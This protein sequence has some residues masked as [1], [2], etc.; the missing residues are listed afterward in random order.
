[1][2]RPDWRPL[3]LEKPQPLLHVME[4]IAATSIAAHRLSG[5][6]AEGWSVKSRSSNRPMRICWGCSG[7]HSCPGPAP[8]AA[9]KVQWNWEY[10]GT[11]RSLQCPDQLSWCLPWSTQAAQDGPPL[12]RINL[13]RIGP[14][15]LTPKTS[16]RATLALLKH[17]LRRAQ[18]S[19][20]CWS[21]TSGISLGHGST[22]WILHSFGP[23]PTSASGLQ[24]SWLSMRLRSLLLSWLHLGHFTI[25]SAALELLSSTHQSQWHRCT[26]L[27]CCHEW[28]CLLAK[29]EL[30]CCFWDNNSFLHEKSG[31][32]NGGSSERCCLEPALAEALTN[33]VFSECFFLL[34]SLAEGLVLREALF[35]VEALKAKLG[36]FFALPFSCLTSSCSSAKASS[37]LMP[38]TFWASFL[39]KFVLMLPE[40]LSEVPLPGPLS[41][42]FLIHAVILSSL[43]SS[44]LGS[45]EGWS[46]RDKEF[47][48]S[49]SKSSATAY[50]ISGWSSSSVQPFSSSRWK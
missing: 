7:S 21:S 38:C 50:K 47:W 42:T 27:R 36:L 12:S 11:K 6:V 25:R 10:T 20:R 31:G 23:K 17:H 43:Q 49:S 24:L 18:P 32:G 15:Q 22:V 48:S 39:H 45:S 14:T 44:D 26:Y 5:N 13:L 8:W 16:G 29:A 46:L 9:S 28:S 1:M 2:L 37:L 33:A 3:T 35:L 41:F 4:H 40:Q 19:Q 34:L 30:A